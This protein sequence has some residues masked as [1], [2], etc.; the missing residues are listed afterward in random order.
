MGR[1]RDIV[2]PALES[3]GTGTDETGSVVMVL[4][5]NRRRIGG[6]RLAAGPSPGTVYQ[7]EDGSDQES[8]QEDEE[9]VCALRIVHHTLSLS[10]PWMRSIPSRAGW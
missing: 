8:N 10:P 2:S 6:R 9:D 1:S 4:F 7:P 3:G 5:G